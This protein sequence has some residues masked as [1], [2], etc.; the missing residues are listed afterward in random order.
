MLMTHFLLPLSGMT[1]TVDASA[2]WEIS[3]FVTLISTLF[4]KLF[5]IYRYYIN[6]GIFE[7]SATD[8]LNVGKD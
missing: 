3:I 5:F 2:A 8:S 6:K 7:S 4:N 1:D